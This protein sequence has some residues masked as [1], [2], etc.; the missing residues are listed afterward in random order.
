MQEKSRIK[1][2]ILKFIEYKGISKYEFYKRT[3]IT[4]G[5][6]NQNNGMSEENTAIFI[7][8]YPEVSIEWLITGNG[9]MLKDNIS[10]LS[11]EE[12]KPP[13]GQITYCQRCVDKDEVIKA[14]Q[15]TIETQQHL[16]NCLEA[17]SPQQSGQKRKAG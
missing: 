1:K 6:L 3:G 4:R 9:N 16:I 8:Y 12:E 11:K 5:V 13:P 10:S 15:K 14:M 17:T 7:A 2:N